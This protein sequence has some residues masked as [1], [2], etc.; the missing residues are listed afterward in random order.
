[1]GYH[2]CQLFTQTQ[3]VL[4]CEEISETAGMPKTAKEL[5]VELRVASG[6][7][8]AFSVSDCGE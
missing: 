6:L 1:M 7:V 4:N 2:L 8:E 5:L 3:A